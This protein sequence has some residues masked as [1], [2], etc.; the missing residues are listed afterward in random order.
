MS[1]TSRLD[2]LQQRHPAL[3]LPIAVVY[4]FADD[5]GS[6]LAALITYYGFLSLLPLLLLLST[7]TGFVLSGDGSARD[8]ILSSA[9][10]QFPVIGQQL[11]EDPTGLGGGRVGLVIG[12]LGALY[13]GLG[14]GQAVQHAMNT[15]WAVP[16]NNRPNPLLA[17]LRGLL[18][19]GTAGLAVLLT[20]VLSSL[21]AG[22]GALTKG[23]GTPVQVAITAGFVVASVAV[24]TGVFVLAF[25]H[26]T[27][28]PLTLRQVL[29]GGVCAAVVYQLL[30]SFGATYVSH[31]VRSA[32]AVNSVFAVVL[33]LLAFIYLAS[34]ATVLCAEINVVRVDKL[35][36]RALLTPFTDDVELTPGD[37]KAYTGTAK[38]ARSKGFEQ[39]DV[40]FDK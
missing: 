26:A 27:T 23:H 2:R 32:S 34:A 10:H 18:L 15:V 21:A 7:V 8:A 16:R 12:L 36:P 14:V 13:G 28:R 40:T 39:V 4:K 1:F 20:T 35:Y 30:Q 24:N 31:V 6:Y 37:E 38:A 19:L 22:A 17:R 11:E 9:L 5:Q 29:P 3:G 25:R 33:G